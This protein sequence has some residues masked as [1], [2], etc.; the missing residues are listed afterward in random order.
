M[1]KILLVL[2]C[3]FLAFN[4]YAVVPVTDT[5]ASTKLS[6]QLTNMVEQ[7]NIARENK[8]QL[9]GV[10]WT[11]VA[12]LATQMGNNSTSESSNLSYANSSAATTFQSAYPGNVANSDYSA[13]YTNSAQLSLNTF[14]DTLSGLQASYNALTTEDQNRLDSIQNKVTSAIGTLQAQTAN[15]HMIN[16]MVIQLT[17]LRSA[18]LA[19]ASSATAY[20]AQQVGNEAVK[21]ANLNT[22]LANG[23][24]ETVPTYGNYSVSFE[25]SGFSY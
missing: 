24:K 14:K 4:T 12:N 18:F 8:Q 19:Q 15:S 10:S 20:M 5:E 25:S 7:L 13:S 6:E 22:I 11:G 3:S 21:K 23:A 9:T 1:K 16:E 2:V 17:E